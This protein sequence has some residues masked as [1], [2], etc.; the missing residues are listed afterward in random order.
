MLISTRLSPD[1][2]RLAALGLPDDREWYRFTV[3]A[4][5]GLPW[6]VGRPW[7]RKLDWSA[8]GTPVDSGAREGAVLELGEP[9]DE[10][11]AQIWVQYI[12]D[13]RE[14]VFLEAGWDPAAGRVRIAMHGLEQHPSDA[15]ISSLGRARE[16]FAPSEV[17][18]EPT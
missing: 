18:E 9:G 1:D 15:Q 10:W 14:A 4:G 11:S 2:P 13:P 8:I 16:W 12:G 7:P 3:R 6:D 17:G 5:L